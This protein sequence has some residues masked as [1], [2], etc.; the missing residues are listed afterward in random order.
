MSNESIPARWGIHRDSQRCLDKKCQR[1]HGHVGTHRSSV[2]KVLNGIHELVSES[3]G[4]EDDDQTQPEAP[5]LL[6][7]STLLESRT[8]TRNLRKGAA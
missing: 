3:W 1:E 8:V 2:V 7:R 5:S 6:A 4:W